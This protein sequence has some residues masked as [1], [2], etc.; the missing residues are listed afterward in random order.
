MSIYVDFP[1]SSDIWKVSNPSIVIDKYNK[2]YDNYIKQIKQLT[3]KSSKILLS[4]R[5]NKKYMVFDGNRYIHFGDIRYE[6]FTKHL[7]N[8][9]RERYLK[10]FSHPDGNPYSPYNL[11]LYLLW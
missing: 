9:R 7:D 2:I 4:T 10:R 1:K 11:S 8:N 6:D 3:N 5:K